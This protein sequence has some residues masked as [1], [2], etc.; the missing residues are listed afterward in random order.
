MKCRKCGMCCKAIPLRFGLT[1]LAQRKNCADAKFI[2]KHWLSI[3]HV[4]ALYYNKEL[5]S[6]GGI[7]FYTCLLLDKR[8]RC[9]VHNRKPKICSGYPWY[10][11]KEKRDVAKLIRKEGC[12]YGH[13]E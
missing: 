7:Y 4:Q 10:G 6:G 9:K 5:V 2:I 11:E 13:I 3:S 1:H 8:N 12:G